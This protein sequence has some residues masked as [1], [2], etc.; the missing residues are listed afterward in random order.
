[1]AKRTI[2]LS[3]D[4]LCE[5]ISESVNRI[6][7]EGAYGYP[8]GIDDII[9]FWENDRALQ[10]WNFNLCNAL[11]KKRARGQEISADILAN[12]SVMAKIQQE[13]FRRYRQEWGGRNT[14]PNPRA[15]RQF[16]ANRMVERVNCGEFE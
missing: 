3:E 8:D 11:Q 7:S 12:S 6:I 4:K 5:M 9:L 2:R 15:F 1:M 10:D 16:L 13:T 14:N